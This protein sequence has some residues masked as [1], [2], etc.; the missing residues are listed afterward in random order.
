[1]QK[2]FNDYMKKSDQ[3]MKDFQNEMNKFK[4]NKK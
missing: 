3:Q 2:M 1:M 4:N